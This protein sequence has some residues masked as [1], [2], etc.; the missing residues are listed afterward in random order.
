MVYQHG[1]AFCLMHYR[2]D[3]C[4]HEEVFWNS[5]DGVTPFGMQCP[6]CGGM[7]MLHVDWDKDRCVPDYVPEAGQ[8]VWIDMPESLKRPLARACVKEAALPERMKEQ[9][10]EQIVAEFRPGTPWLIRWT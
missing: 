3:E 2:C 6:Q 1:E 5:R 9:L 4:G 10:V 7:N 8:G